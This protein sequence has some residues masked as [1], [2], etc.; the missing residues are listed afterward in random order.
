MPVIQSSSVT[1]SEA[2]AFLGQIATDR[3]CEAADRGEALRLRRL[4]VDTAACATRYST[5]D[6]DL[7]AMLEWID[8]PVAEE[9]EARHSIAASRLVGLRRAHDLALGAAYGTAAGDPLELEEL[10]RAAMG[11]LGSAID[12]GAPLDAVRAVLEEHLGE[13]P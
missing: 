12:A 7:R 10:I 2:L 8:N 11:A 3:I 9:R 13:S 4:I 5:A 6:E 1:S